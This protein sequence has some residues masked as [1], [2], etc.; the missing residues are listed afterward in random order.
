MARNV[1]A[2]F[3]FTSVADDSKNRLCLSYSQTSIVCITF[4]S[5]SSFAR[6]VCIYEKEHVHF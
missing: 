6:I 2:N 3:S 1:P 5:F 4:N